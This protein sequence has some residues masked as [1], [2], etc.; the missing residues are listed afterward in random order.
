MGMRLM[1]LCK[2]TRFLS[3]QIRS[4]RELTLYVIRT[5]ALCAAVALTFDVANQ[6]T[7]FAGWAAALRSWV[8]TVGVV[9]VIATP[10]ARAIGAANLALYHASRT[11]PLTGL[12]NRRA[13]FEQAADPEA[14]L[15]LMIA[16]LDRFKAVNDAYGHMAG[17]EVL[18]SIATILQRELEQFG[19][20]G[21]LGGEEFALICTGLDPEWLLAKLDAFRKV[22]AATPILCGGVSVSVTISAGVA[23]R[24][25]GQSFAQIYAEADRALYRAKSQ[26]RNQIVV[27]GCRPEAIEPA[28]FA[29]AG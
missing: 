4:E 7:F 26:G 28:A 18:R 3:S 16:D 29:R 23:F 19:H 10:V 5:T 11:D 24:E 21:R 20:V 25:H 8:I 9:L 2:A 13:L 1:L 14:Y 27:A 17:D 6:L 22:V 12:L 15:V